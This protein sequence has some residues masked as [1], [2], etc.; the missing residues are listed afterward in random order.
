MEPTT[1]SGVVVVAGAVVVMGFD[2]DIE[3]FAASMWA[4]N[5]NWSKLSRLNNL[6]RNWCMTY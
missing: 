2:A 6:G 5:A 4:D 3:S 1:A